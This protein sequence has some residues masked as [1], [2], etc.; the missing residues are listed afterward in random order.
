M[1]NL[2]ER[3]AASLQL[4]TNPRLNKLGYRR[5][6]YLH[7][8]YFMLYRVVDD[9]AIVDSIFHFFEDYENKMK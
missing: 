5:I 3:V 6:N 7:H 8:D 4:C 9:K 2:Q 1:Q